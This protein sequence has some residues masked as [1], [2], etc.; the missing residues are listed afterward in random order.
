MANV[1]ISAL[2]A[3][4][5]STATSLLPIVEGGITYKITKNDFLTQS[6]FN[7]GNVSGTTNVDM[8]IYR[9]FIFTLTGDVNVVLQNA[10][11]GVEYLFWVYATGA[12][13]I[14]SMSVDGFDLYSVGGTLPNPTNN[15]W[16]LYRGNTIDGVFVLN[17]I[18][19]FSQVI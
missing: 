17:E 15:R 16:N 4:T 6:A 9:Q 1:P 11:T 13:A 7:A 18:G 10:E 8:S 3:L 5:A 14:T 12:S 2:S 19:N